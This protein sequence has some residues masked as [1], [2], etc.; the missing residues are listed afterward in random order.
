M[1]VLLV[2]LDSASIRYA[3]NKTESKETIVIAK[4]D[5]SQ[6]NL[7]LIKVICDKRNYVLSENN[8]SI[9]IEN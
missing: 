1:D 7:K 4:K 6:E 9:F 2:V 5:I 8:N 3:Y